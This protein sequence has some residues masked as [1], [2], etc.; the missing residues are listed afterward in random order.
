MFTIIQKSRSPAITILCGC[1]V[2]FAAIIF[3]KTTTVLNMSIAYIVVGTIPVGISEIPV[4]G[5]LPV[6]IIAIIIL[7]VCVFLLPAVMLA[8][9]C[10]R[11]IPDSVTSLLVIG[12]L[13]MY[14]WL[15]LF[16]PV[17]ESL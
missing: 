12:W 16:Y 5:N 4:I 11:W 2:A 15:Y 17:A 8:R 1:V 13:L 3:V 10:Q 7:S 9:V 6:R 14:L